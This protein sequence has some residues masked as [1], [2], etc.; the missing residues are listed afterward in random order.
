MGTMPLSTVVVRKLLVAVGVQPACGIPST[1]SLY[2]YGL[3]EILTPL[4]GTQSIDISLSN[5]QPL[6]PEFFRIR[7]HNVDIITLRLEDNIR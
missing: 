3:R 1:L 4:G 7:T 2:I 6:L 5:Y